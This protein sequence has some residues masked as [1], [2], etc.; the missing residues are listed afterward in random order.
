VT[1]KKVARE[2]GPRRE[3]DPPELVANSDKLRRVLG[4]KPRYLDLKDTVKTAWDFEQ[5][6]R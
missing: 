1:G 5:R 6:R 2:I 4:W 3:G